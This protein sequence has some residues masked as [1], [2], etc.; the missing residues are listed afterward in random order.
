M[1]CCSS[2]CKFLYEIGFITDG[3]YAI[4]PDDTTPFDA[5]CDKSNGGWAV[6]QRRVD[7]SVDFYRGWADYVAGFGDLTG[8]FWTGLDR[9]HAMTSG[10]T[11]ELYVSME[12]F[13][14]ETAWAQYSS[15]SVGDAASGYLMTVSGYTGTA[16]DAMAQHNNAKFTTFDHDQDIYA[17][18]CASVYKGAWWYSACHHSNPN[19]QYLNGEHSSFA[20]GINWLQF[21]GFYYSLKTIEFKARRV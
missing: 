4:N 1:M 15:F 17:N 6:F 16:G 11:T 9:I 14:G 20:D 10:S 12:S 13:E 3:V 2:D 19:G 18:N 7:D 5:Y 21:K 8:N